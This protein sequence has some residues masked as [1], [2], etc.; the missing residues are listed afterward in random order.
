[1]KKLATFAVLSLAVAA[2]AAFAGGG[3]GGSM[4]A[5]QGAVT[6][7][8]GSISQGNTVASSQTIGTGGSYQHAQAGTGGTASMSGSIMPSGA[9]VSTSTTQYSTTKTSGMTWGNAPGM[10]NG[11]I[12]NGAGAYGNTD[13]AAAA[14]GAFQMGVIGGFGSFGGFGHH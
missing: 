3:F 2:P 11:S 4:G 10:V 6:G 14:Q 5:Y 12:A 13:T 1:M 8:V 7:S 9:S